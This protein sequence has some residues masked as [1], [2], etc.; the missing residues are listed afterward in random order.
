L[1]TETNEPS[2][3]KDSIEEQQ[4]YSKLFHS[5]HNLMAAQESSYTEW[6]E[7]TP[8]EY[9]IIRITFNSS[10]TYVNLIH[11]LFKEAFLLPFS[12]AITM[13]KVIT[14]YRHW[15]YR[16]TSSIP[17]FIEEPLT[18]NSNNNNLNNGKE[19]VRAGISNLLRVFVSIASNVFLLEVPTD[20]PLML[21][22]QVDMCKRV[23]NIYRYMVMKIEM[24]KLAWSATHS[25]ILSYFHIVLFLGNDYFKYYFK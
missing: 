12:H 23:L 11:S 9:N 4:H 24:D 8:L 7:P 21:E 16:T 1:R 20:K 14:V 22:E 15:I 6:R 13:R 18:S 3:R 5:H 2:D 17:L 19:D 10:R 25:F